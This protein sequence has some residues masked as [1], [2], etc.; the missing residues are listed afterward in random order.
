MFFSDEAS[1]RHMRAPGEK[2]T[3]VV[4]VF[5]PGA[6]AFD[7]DGTLV[8]GSGNGKTEHG[9][10][11]VDSGN[12]LAVDLAGEWLYAAQTFRPAAIQR[13]NLRTGQTED[14]MRAGPDDTAAGPD[15]MV[16]DGA[17]N[18]FVTANGAG[19]VWRVTPDK[20]YCA[21]LEGLPPFPDGP[22]AVATGS[23]RSAFPPENI[24]VVAFD[25]R[26]HE[27]AGVAAP[28]ASGERRATRDAR[29]SS[30]PSTAPPPTRPARPNP[31]TVRRP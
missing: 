7:A 4:A 23:A 1:L 10:A 8:M 24:Y 27:V 22:S 26:V 18:L 6:L 13:V 19:E 14:W 5:E 9:R 11:K 2:S 25:G 20:S 31:V 3:V 29:R 12:G 16:R 17:G 28:D 15:G 30:S 21:V